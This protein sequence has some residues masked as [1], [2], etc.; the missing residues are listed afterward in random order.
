MTIKP[1]YRCS[2]DQY[3][4]R[5]QYKWVMIRVWVCIEAQ[6]CRMRYSVSS[7]IILLQLQHCCETTW[8]QL[9]H[10]IHFCLPTLHAT[11]YLMQIFC[12]S[13]MWLVNTYSIPKCLPVIAN[14]CTSIGM[15]TAFLCLMKCSATLGSSQAVWQ[16]DM[17]LLSVLYC[18]GTDMKISQK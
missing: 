2:I 6:L 11:D 17:A 13:P 7:Y 8:T 18:N 3:I 12:L 9:V 16:D 5:V 4:Q 15:Q 1:W 14:C 10:I